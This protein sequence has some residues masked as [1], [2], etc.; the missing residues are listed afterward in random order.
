VRPLFQR[1]AADAEVGELPGVLKAAGAQ[2]IGAEAL[3][4]RSA[5]AFG[6]CDVQA[7]PAVE[8]LLLLE[9]AVAHQATEARVGPAAAHAK[10]P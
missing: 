5:Q 1:A 9:Q 4:E 2:S 3:V 7:G 6:C 8:Q 10:A